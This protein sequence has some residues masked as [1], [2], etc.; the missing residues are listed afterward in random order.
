MSE[1]IGFEEPVV[2]ARRQ[3][4]RIGPS[5]DRIASGRTNARPQTAI[6][7]GNCQSIGLWRLNSTVIEQAL[8]AFAM[9]FPAA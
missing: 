6:F 3:S 8:A 1:G 5:L 4:S 2:S 9:E 7:T